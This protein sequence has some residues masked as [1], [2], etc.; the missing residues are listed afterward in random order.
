M[1]SP[2]LVE[3]LAQSTI[4][5]IP[6]DAERDRIACAALGRRG[7]T[8]WTARRH[9]LQ[10]SLASALRTVTDCLGPLS[11]G[12]P[13]GHKLALGSAPADPASCGFRECGI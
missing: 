10:V 13:S 7:S 12:Q 1:Y 9:R 5:E 6:A 2:A 3:M 11:Y 4:Q 8:G